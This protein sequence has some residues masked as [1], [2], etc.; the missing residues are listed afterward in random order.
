MAQN[1]LGALL[2]A[3]RAWRGRR[4]L[5]LP[6]WRAFRR[7]RAGANASRFRRPTVR[8]RSS[9]K[10]ITPIRPRCALRWRC[11]ARQDPG[12]TDDGSPSSATCWSLAQTARRCTRNWLADLS[13]NRVDLLFGAGPLTRALFD[14]APASMRAAWAERSSE[15]T[16]EVARTLRNGDVAMVKGSNASRMGP[17]VAAL[18]EQLAR[19]Q[20]QDAKC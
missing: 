7:R 4:P 15:L 8:R 2:A 16:A 10:A 6:R 18:R 19:A 11:L 17:L 1:A 9:T 13:S 5:A 3:Q 14:A 12:R 20:D